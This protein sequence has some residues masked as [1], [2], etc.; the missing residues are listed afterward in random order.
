MHQKYQD[1]IASGALEGHCALCDA[2][3][4]KT[5]TLWK[6]IDND[7]P[8]DLVAT[9]HHMLVPLRHASD[10]EVTKEEWIEY[11]QIKQ[12]FVQ[13]EYEYILEATNKRK[14]IPAHFHV[15][16]LITK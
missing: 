16:L 10:S 8:Y 3:P 11:Q 1:L 5:F 13:P 4:L 15:H 12:S 2:K 6:L 9:T 7:F 14:S